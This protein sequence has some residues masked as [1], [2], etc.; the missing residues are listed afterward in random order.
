MKTVIV[1]GSNGFIGSALAKKFLQDGARVIGIVRNFE[2]L[3]ELLQ[4]KEFIPIQAELE[5]YHKLD[6]DIREIH[7][8]DIDAFFHFAWD[9]VFGESFKDYSRQIKNIQY[10]CDT[11]MTAIKSGC[12]K[13]ILAGTYN[14][15][16]IA[17]RIIGNYSEPRYTCIYSAAKVA[18]DMMCKTLAYNHHIEYNSGLICMAYGEGNKSKMLANTVIEQLCNGIRPKLVEADGLY[19]MIYIDD[20][21]QAFISIEEK[22]KNQKSYYIGH[23]KLDTFGN[24]ITQMRDVLNPQME[25]VFGE[26]KETTRLDYNLIDLDAL[27]NDTGFECQADFKTTIKK[28]ADWLMKMR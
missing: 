17:T 21:V 7:S 28:T 25:L 10:S 19:D 26:Y 20:I 12:K 16:E 24:Y 3:E 5:E 23:R 13:F 11:L 22:G 2:G 27:Y 1:T 18:S 15:Y 4:F 6:Q 8:G 9:G 14:Q